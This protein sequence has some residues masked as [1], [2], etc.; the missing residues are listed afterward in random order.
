MLTFISCEPFVMAK[1]SRLIASLMAKNGN[2]PSKE[3]VMLRGLM[4]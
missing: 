4:R 1:I 3:H 2:S